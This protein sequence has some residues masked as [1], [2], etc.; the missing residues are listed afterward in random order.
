MHLAIILSSHNTCIRTRL[1]KTQECLR[2]RLAPRGRYAWQGLGRMG[3]ALTRLRDLPAA[4]AAYGPE[5]AERRERSLQHT[6]ERFVQLFLLAPPP[7]I[8]TLEQ[9]ATALIGAPQ[10]P[11]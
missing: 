5:L 4:H 7:R 10:L 9:A 6:A 2:Q 3:G 11:A 8:L 1:H